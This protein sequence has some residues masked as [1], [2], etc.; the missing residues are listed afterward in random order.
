M[1]IDERLKQIY[2]NTKNS[3]LEVKTAKL[4]CTIISEYVKPITVDESSREEFLSCL[5]KIDYAWKNFCKEHKEFKP[6]D[7]RNWVLANDTDDYIKNIL[8]W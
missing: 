6:Q 3:S 5:K 2:E 7:Y 8:N 4:I 1:F